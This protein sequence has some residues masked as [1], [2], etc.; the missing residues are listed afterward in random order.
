MTDWDELQRGVAAAYD[1]QR[2][3][4]WPSPHPA[5]TEPADEEYSR[6]TEPERYRIVQARSRVWRD[7]LAE[8]PGVSVES[9]EPGAAHGHPATYVAQRCVRVSS[10]APGT[11]D[12]VLLE[13]DVRLTSGEGTLPVVRIAVER[14][15]LQVE[16][17]PDCGCDACDSGSLDLLDAVDRAIRRVVEGPLVVLRGDGWAADWSPGCASSHGLGSGILRRGMDHEDAIRLCERLAAGDAVRLPDRTEAFVG[18]SW[19]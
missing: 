2:L 8:L 19:L 12:L 1:D 4:T 6:V 3:P 18:R 11:L 9:I 15:D 14:P 13:Q 7:T 5:M 10:S 17:Q 16:A